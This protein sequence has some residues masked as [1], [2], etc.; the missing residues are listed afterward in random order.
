MQGQI[1]ERRSVRVGH[2][3]PFLY[4]PV[5]FFFFLLLRVCKNLHDEIK[6]WNLNPEVLKLHRKFS[7]GTKG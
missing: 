3:W 5:W 1:A 2:L 6:S 4:T 7:S